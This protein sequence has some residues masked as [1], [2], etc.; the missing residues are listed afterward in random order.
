[1][2]GKRNTKLPGPTLMREEVN[3]SQY[4][5]DDLNTYIVHVPESCSEVDK[6]AF[7]FVVSK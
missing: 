3:L 6:A 1:V 7:N 2:K 5:A 4:R